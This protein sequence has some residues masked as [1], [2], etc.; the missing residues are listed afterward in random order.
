MALF[1]AEITVKVVME[2]QILGE[3]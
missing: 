1:L 3:N 2:R